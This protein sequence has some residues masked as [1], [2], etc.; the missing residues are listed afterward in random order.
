M[1]IN[2]YQEEK[3]QNDPTWTKFWRF[4]SADVHHKYLTKFNTV[5]LQQPTDLI[6]DQNFIN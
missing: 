3:K 5:K 2:C 6:P 1:S 4:K